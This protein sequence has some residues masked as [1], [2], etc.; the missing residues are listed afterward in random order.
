MLHM[1]NGEHFTLKKKLEGSIK[2]QKS[3]TR[4]VLCIDIYKKSED[5]IGMLYIF[6]QNSSHTRCTAYLAI[7][8]LQ[9]LTSM[10]VKT[11]ALMSRS[12]LSLITAILLPNRIFVV[13]IG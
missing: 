5:I 4:I 2:I 1:S 9:I 13:S 11:S 3:M 10:H 12:T 7:S 8:R 6:E